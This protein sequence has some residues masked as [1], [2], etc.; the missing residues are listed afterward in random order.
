MTKSVFM[1][2]GE[3]VAIFQMVMDAMLP[4]SMGPIE[5]TFLIAFI[6]SFCLG[7]VY[8]RRVRMCIGQLVGQG[9]GQGNF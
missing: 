2:M 8:S 3:P 9:I 6:V 1:F 4:L 5:V 7:L